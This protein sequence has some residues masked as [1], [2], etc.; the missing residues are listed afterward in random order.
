MHIDCVIS[1]TGKNSACLGPAAVVLQT[2]YSVLAVVVMAKRRYGTARMTVTL[3]W[4][5]TQP[6]EKVP[7]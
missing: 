5:M 2:S 7:Q 3:A 1:G 6:P 4:T